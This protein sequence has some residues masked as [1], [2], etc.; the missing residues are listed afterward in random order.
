MRGRRPDRGFVGTGRPGPFQ[1]SKCGELA[2]LWRDVVEVGEL[3]G[4]VAV[5]SVGRWG[6]QG[7][8]DVRAVSA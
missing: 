8:A 7:Q 5:L 6:E 1:A 2:S 3:I 4:L